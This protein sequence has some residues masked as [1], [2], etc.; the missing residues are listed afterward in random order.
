MILGANSGCKNTS[1]VF[2]FCFAFGSK[3]IFTLKLNLEKPALIGLCAPSHGLQ[4]SFYELKSIFTSL[5][6]SSALPEQI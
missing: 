1:S 6:F 2:T 5:T 3:T 4:H